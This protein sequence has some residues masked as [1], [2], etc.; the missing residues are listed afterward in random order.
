MCTKHYTCVQR[1]HLDI[2][3]Y[4]PSILYIILLHV[5]K[6]YKLK[7]VQNTIHVFQKLIQIQCCFLVHCIP[8]CCTC[9]KHK[10]RIA[11]IRVFKKCFFFY[12]RYLQRL[13]NYLALETSACK[14]LRH[15]FTCLY[16]YNFY[17]MNLPVHFVY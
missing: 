13:L 15:T 5:F 10:T 7:W 14:C 1:I 12:L 11:C 4:F 16:V 9:V 2:V 8:S 6:I 3:L 17:A